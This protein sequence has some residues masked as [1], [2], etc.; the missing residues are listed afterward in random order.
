MRGDFL[1]AFRRHDE[2]RGIRFDKT[3]AAQV[4]EERAHRRYLA[5]DRGARL[6]VAMERADKPADGI[7]VEVLRLQ[8]AMFAGVVAGKGDELRQIAFVGGDGMRRRVA[9]Q[10]DVVEKLAELFHRSRSS[11]ARV[12]VASFRSA[13]FR[14]FG[15]ASMMPKVMFD[16]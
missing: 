11:S 3:L 12:D 10:A 1:L 2:R 13:R 9:I 8:R 5:R 6:L 15:G 7:E 14:M 4:A 16:G